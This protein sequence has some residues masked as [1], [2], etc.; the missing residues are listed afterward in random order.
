MIKRHYTEYEESRN[1]YRDEL[2]SELLELKDEAVPEFEALQTKFRLSGFMTTALSQFNRYQLVLD[3]EK[4][5]DKM[6][7]LLSY[8][9]RFACSYFNKAYHPGQMVKVQY[10]ERVLEQMGEENLNYMDYESWLEFYY[11]FLVTRCTT[12]INL[13]KHTTRERMINSTILFTDEPD[14]CMVEF[15]Q[16]LVL[17]E[18]DTLTVWQKAWDAIHYFVENDTDPDKILIKERMLHLEASTLLLYK[19]LFTGNSDEFN[20]QLEETLT[21]HKEYWGRTHTTGNSEF[22]DHNG[23]ISWRILACCSV[24]HD[25]GLTINVK[26]DYIPEWLYKGEVKDW[27]L[28]I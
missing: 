4:E 2:S 24:A 18:V 10:G 14:F 28:K 16:S 20:L 15:M 3:Q 5:Q 23:W 25:S 22:N 8:T 17:K 13:L 6:Q 21:Y 12:G 11:L 27:G 19:A 7:E 9:L 1:R 26:S